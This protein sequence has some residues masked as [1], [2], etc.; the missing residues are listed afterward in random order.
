MKLLV[1][2][3]NC[4]C[5]FCAMMCDAWKTLGGDYD[6][7]PLT[8]GD[9]KQYSLIKCLT[10]LGCPEDKA[11]Q[12][13][14]NFWKIE[15]FY[16]TYY[17]DMIERVPILKL[18]QEYKDKGYYIEL[19]TLNTS[20]E[21]A[22]SKTNKLLKD[23]FLMELV[24]NVVISTYLTNGK[25]QQKPIDYD[26]VIED[27]PNYIEHYLKHNKKGIVFMPIWEYNKHLIVNDRVKGLL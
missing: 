5:N 14:N 11:T 20:P 24:D 22:I 13:M 21:M 25:F 17:S 8:M 23:R 1:D 7:Y 15:D 16:Q 26:V 4:L 12:M 9:F 6:K 19:N 10:E 2:Y 18:L 3:D 27:S